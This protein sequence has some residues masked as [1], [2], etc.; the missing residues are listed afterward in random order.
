VLH[1]VCG[2]TSDIIYPKLEELVVKTFG[3]LLSL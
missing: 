3:W 2:N 1:T